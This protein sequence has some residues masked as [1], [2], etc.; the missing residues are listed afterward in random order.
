MSAVDNLGVFKKNKKSYNN[1]LKDIEEHS[2]T[3]TVKKI[4]TVDTYSV[5]HN[6]GWMVKVTDLEQERNVIYKIEALN[7]GSFL[8]VREYIWSA[9]DKI[10]DISFDVK[11]EGK[12]IYLIVNDANDSCIYQILDFEGYADLEDNEEALETFDA[13]SNVYCYNDQYKK[14]LVHLVVNS[15]PVVFEIMTVHD[16]VTLKWESLSIN[17]NQHI[18]DVDVRATLNGGIVEIEVHSNYKVS[19]THMHCTELQ[20]INI[21]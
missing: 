8:H 2:K 17:N 4:D 15:E 13:Y 20:T 7:A 9:D 1:V 3:Y 10:D 12:D 16:G 14:L 19:C 6:I 5:R 21:V 11:L 18:K